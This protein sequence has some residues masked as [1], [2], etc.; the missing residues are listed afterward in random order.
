MLKHTLIPMAVLMLLSGEGGTV[1]AEEG[2]IS[3]IEAPQAEIPQP[4]VQKAPVAARDLNASENQ[5]ISRLEDGFAN[6]EVSESEYNQRKR[7]IR[8]STVPEKRRK[9]DLLNRHISF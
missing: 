1:W 7:D 4:V 6:N 8:R 9:D 2:T 3:Q 5:E